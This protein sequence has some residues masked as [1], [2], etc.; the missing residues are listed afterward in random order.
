MWRG[1]VDM[2]VQAFRMSPLAVK[3]KG[4][5]CAARQGDELFVES[6]NCSCSVLVQTY[7]TMITKF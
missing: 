6:F 4:N 1:V 2:G 5:A 3:R 7:T